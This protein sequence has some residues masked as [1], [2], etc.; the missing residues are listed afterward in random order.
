METGEMLRSVR[1]CSA[2]M[3]YHSLWLPYGISYRAVAPASTEGWSNLIVSTSLVDG[4]NLFLHLS[5][6]FGPLE[7]HIQT[8]C[9][10][11]HGVT[12]FPYKSLLSATKVFLC[13]AKAFPST[14]W[15]NS[16]IRAFTLWNLLFPSEFPES[17]RPL[18]ALRN[19]DPCA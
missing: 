5:D 11:P 18:T 3:Q 14:V 2:E 8:L 10:W 16:W 4:G 12:L 6:R 13:S 19:A 7:A 9:L 1:F 15:S 17:A